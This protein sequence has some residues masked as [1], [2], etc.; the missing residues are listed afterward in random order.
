MSDQIWETGPPPAGVRVGDDVL[1][2]RHATSLRRF[3]SEQDPGLDIGAGCRIHTW[4]E[5]S[6]EP[7]GRVVVGERTV[8]VGALVMCNER[9]EIGSDVVVSYDVTIADCDFHPHAAEPRRADAIA[10]SPDRDLA[11][12]QPITSRPVVIEDGAWIGIGAIILKGVRVGAG[13]RVAAGSVVTRD[14]A[15]GAEVAGN[16]AR[17]VTA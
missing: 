2:E 1:F 11:E 13:A 5:F 7:A 6:V 8:L 10:I 17:E 16:P 15:P 12:R 3:R 9:V 4:T 14:V